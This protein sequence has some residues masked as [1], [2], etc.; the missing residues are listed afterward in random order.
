[1]GS[2]DSLGRLDLN[3]LVS[4]AAL[5]EERSVSR[6]A[7][8][9]RLSQPALSASLSKLR[10]HFDDQLL[11]RHGNLYELTPLAVRLLEPVEMALSSVRRVFDSE[12][13]FDPSVSTR[14]FQIYG[15]DY[16]FATVGQVASQ[17]AAAEAPGVKFRFILHS[18]RIVEEAHDLLRTFDG[19]LI[20]HGHISG[21]GNDDLWNDSWVILADAQHPD[22]GENLSLADLAS[23]PWVLA[24]QSKSAF[25]SA[26]QQLKSLGIEFD[27]DVVVQ[28]F[29]AIPF[30][31][32]RTRR[33]ALV[34]ASLLA[35]IIKIPGLRVY[36]PPFEVV[37]VA[38]ALWWHQLHES[39][40][41]HQWMR[42]LFRR[43]GKEMQQGK[44]KIDMGSGVTD[45]VSDLLKGDLG[46]FQ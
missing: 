19:L 12:S 44:W 41:G 3:L 4:L 29:L 42:S 31:V 34:Q 27:V 43:A 26:D 30:Y 5:L 25:T 35:S 9:L 17:L 45:S 38:N 24:Y 7:E 46:E 13:D 15:S 36:R 14:E 11:S 23:N 21:L 16:G 10:R 18:T 32:T 20:P 33:L 28:S 2:G 8:R 40:P 1:M 22:L 37:P 39:D 6:A